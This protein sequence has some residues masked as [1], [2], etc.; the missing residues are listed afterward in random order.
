MNSGQARRR[1]DDLEARLRY[2]ME[3]LEQE[4]RLSALPPVVIG[5]AVIVPESLLRRLRGQQAVPDEPDQRERERIDRLAMDAVMEKERR[6]GRKP[7]RMP[8]DNP[9][10][11]IESAEQENGHLLF[12]EVKGKAAG[13]TTVTVS[14]TQVL[15]AL[16]KPDDFIL[17]IV[18][19]DGESVSEPRYIRRPFQKEPDFGVTSINYDLK[20]LLAQAEPQG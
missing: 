9:G 13:S 1:A 5:G 10:Y 20:Q 7:C 16:N 8:H 6:L 15:T 3:E 2:R 19:V 11:D 14:R 12:I 4:R 17:A 18:E